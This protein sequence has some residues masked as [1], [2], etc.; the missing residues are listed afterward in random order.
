MATITLT[1]A[2]EIAPR[3]LEAFAREYDWTPQIE[4]A[5]G[6]LIDNPETKAQHAKRRVLQMV[7]QFV[8]RSEEKDA[9]RVARRAARQAVNDEVVIT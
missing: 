5:E 9:V 7:H 4:D 3:I 6:N 2:N 8:A 1:F